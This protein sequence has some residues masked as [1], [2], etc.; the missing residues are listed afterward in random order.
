MKL[1]RSYSHRVSTGIAALDEMTCGGLPQG[2][3]YV[4]NGAPGT[5]KTVL[6]LHFLRA[7]VEAGETVLCIALSQRV[8]SICRTAA[9]IGIDTSDVLFRELSS[10]QALD[11]VVG[12]QTVFDVSEVEL[13]QTMAQFT[14]AIESL[15]PQR[16]V[17]DSVSYL[18]MLASNALVY[19]RQLLLLRDYFLSSDITVLLT[20]TQELVPGDS[21]LVATAHGVISLSKVLSSY[22]SQLRYL[23]IAKIRGSDHLSG[24]HDMTIDNRGMHIHPLFDGRLNEVEQ[25]PVRTQ[26][27]SGYERL[28]ELLGGGL[29]SGTSCLLLGPSGTGKSS[30]ATTFADRAVRRGEKVSVYL[31]DELLDTFLTRTRGLGLE[32]DCFKH[33]DRVRIRELRLGSI[34]PGQFTRTVKQDAKQWGAK[35]VIIDSLTGYTSAMPSSHK[36]IPQMHEL[37]TALNRQDVLTI[38]VV[39]QHGVV[40]PNLEEGVDISYLADAVLFLRHFEAGGSLHRAISVYKKRYGAHE[41]GIRELILGEKGIQIGE[42]LKQFAAVLSGTPQFVGETQNMMVA[43]GQ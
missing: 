18:R 30:I 31:F 2:E 38:L 19:R 23:Q 24:L 34:T 11:S 29:L 6:A 22:G 36:I 32:V 26:I 13:E 20:D 28:D 39:A 21:E 8:E 5:G 33:P 4:V 9:S 12:R 40:G 43:D 1:E 14:Q 7:G 27:E 3:M 41:A 17:F 35:I 16:V 37:L 42:P 25:T 15:Q 10:A